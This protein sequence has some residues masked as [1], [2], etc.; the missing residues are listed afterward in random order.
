MNMEKHFLIEF[1]FF[2]PEIVDYLD[3]EERQ[4]RIIDLF[5]RTNR[6]VSLSVSDDE[7]IMWVVMK[8]ESE[9]ELVFVLDSMEFPQHT[10][11]EYF[12]LN[13]HVSVNTF[14]SYS[15]N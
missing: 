5:K 3:F 8:A 10:E 9:S 1:D 4:D 14:E 6:V 11:Y 7:A 15:L 2:D 12:E 13:L